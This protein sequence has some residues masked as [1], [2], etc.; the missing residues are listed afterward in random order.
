MLEWLE[1]QERL[2]H[3]HA[4]DKTPPL[5]EAYRL[6][7]R[8]RGLGG[9]GRAGGGQLDQPAELM[10]EFDIC[11]EAERVFDT[12]MRPR[13]RREYQEPAG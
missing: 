1:C 7:L 2:R 8:T 3:S 12:L 4:F 6:L 10:R 5:P 11:L 13:I 9:I